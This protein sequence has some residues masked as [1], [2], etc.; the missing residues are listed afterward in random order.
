M[1]TLIKKYKH[2]K[3]YFK[4]HTLK[5]IILLIFTSNTSPHQIAQGVAIGAFFSIIPTF[6]IGM[7][8]SLF[9]AWK[10]SLIWYQLI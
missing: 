1:K 3:N 5:D 8:L 10:K 2:L 7:F 6:S 4:K 9:I